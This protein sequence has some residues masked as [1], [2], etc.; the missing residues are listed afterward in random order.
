MR[1]AVEKL[2]GRRVG[3]R[4]LSVAVHRLS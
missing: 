3:A 1:I 2:I 4:R